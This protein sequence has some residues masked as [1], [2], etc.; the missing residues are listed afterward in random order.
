MTKL[1]TR[2]GAEHTGQV[3]TKTTGRTYCVKPNMCNRCGGAGRS[4]RWAFTGFTCFDCGGEGSRGTIDVNLY[5]VDKL[6]K[7]N[8]TKA[9]A[10]AKRAAAAQAKADKAAT[11]AAERAEAFRASRADVIARSAPHM[12]DAFI[13]DVMTRALE[14][15][16]MTD[17]QAAAVLAAVDRI[18]TRAKVRAASGFVGKPGERVELAVTVERVASFERPKFA[19]PWV[20]ETITIVTMRDEAGNAIV[21]KS[22]AFYAERGEKLTFKATIKEHSDFRGE[23]QTV[24]QRIK[25]AA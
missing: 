9:K 14:R 12:A 25:R 2:D 21:S 1:F 20:T 8:A 11:E 7:L 13:A 17:N 4:D 23:K 15:N 24:V 22:T 19:A 10:D 18:E 5:T 6:A 3:Y 16:D